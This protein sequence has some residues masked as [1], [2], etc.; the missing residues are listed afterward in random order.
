MSRP[1][2]FILETLASEQE[3]YITKTGIL[4]DRINRIQTERENLKKQKLIQLLELLEYIDV[5]ESGEEIMNMD[6]RKKFPD[7]RDIKQLKSRI[8]SL[9]QF[10][11]ADPRPSLADVTDG[12]MF[13]VNTI[14]KPY[15]AAAF[16][17]TKIPSA[18]GSFNLSSNYSKGSNCLT[19][20]LNENNG[21][22]IGD[23]VVHLVFDAIGTP[24]PDN[25]NLNLNKYAYCDFPGI[26]LFKHV[27]LNIDR[28]LISDYSTEDVLFYKQFRLRSDK[29]RV[30][31]EGVG[32]EQ[33][34]NGSYYH[35]DQRYTQVLSFKN[36]PQ[37]SKPFQQKLELWI[38]LLFWYNLD[39]KQA[40]WNCLIR[41]NQKQ[42]SIDL[43]G[44]E[45]IIHQLDPDNNIIPYS[46]NFK[47]NVLS[48]DLYSQ[49]IY[50]PP[51]IEDL[52]INRQNIQLIRTYKRHRQPIKFPKGGFWIEGLKFPTETIYYGFRPNSNLNDFSAWHRFSSR[53]LC[54]VP[55]PAIIQNPAVAPVQQLVVRTGSFYTEESPVSQFGFKLHGNDL[56][57]LTP[58]NFYHRFL[59][60]SFKNIV[61]PDDPGAF[62][63]NFKLDNDEDR[64]PSGH[65]QLSK[66][67]ELY[68]E[69]I[70]NDISPQNPATAYFTSICINFLITDEHQNM[71]LKYMA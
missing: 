62:L 34:I 41:G 70:S 52:L 68:I 25:E 54:E 4:L 24:D 27:E 33:P 23:Q 37:T 20:D 18:Q 44:F 64:Q 19:F 6:I 8:E 53:Q 21:P 1:S 71:K 51:E 38:P 69:Y 31:E 16:E 2:A 11:K 39:T 40:L 50:V 47:L 14:F 48:A 12:H 32:Q 49:N 46:N 13:Y 22:F 66:L 28:E 9:N 61:V 17:Y 43:D 3:T 7:I 42:L 59:P 63:I 15:V 5:L 10:K 60:W 26:R 56:Y 45:N 58:A 36:G 57:T 55:I 35:R 65:A 29:R 67:R 30:Y